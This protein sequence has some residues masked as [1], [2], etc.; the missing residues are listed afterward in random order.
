M[1][2][3]SDS[4]FQCPPSV[5]SDL[6]SRS[7][8]GHPL[9]LWNS[10]TCSWSQ[11]PPSPP[12]PPHYETFIPAH[13]LAPS[14]TPCD[15]S[16]SS[17]GDS[18]ANSAFGFVPWFGYQQVDLK[19]SPSDWLSSLFTAGPAGRKRQR[20]NKIHSIQAAGIIT[21]MPTVIHRSRA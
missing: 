18:G 1:K 6:S 3:M 19:S 7:W 10:L 13:G 5:M 8:D 11:I 4:G 20:F 12:P 17:H 21:S 15:G 2:M 14:W 16:T 9:T